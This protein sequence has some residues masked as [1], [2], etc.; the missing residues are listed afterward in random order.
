[1]KEVLLDGLVVTDASV[2][3]FNDAG[4]ADRWGDG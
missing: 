2:A 1:M 3:Q 4:P